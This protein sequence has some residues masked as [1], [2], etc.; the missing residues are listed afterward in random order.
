MVVATS[1]SNS[2]RMKASIA[3][4][5]SVFAHLAMADADAGVGHEFLDARR[6]S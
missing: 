6:D 3:F 2:W 4:S 1:T 5:S